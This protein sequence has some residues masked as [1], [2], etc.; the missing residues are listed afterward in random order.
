MSESESASR[1]HVFIHAYR[2]VRQAIDGA[3]AAA[4]QL[5]ADPLARFAFNAEREGAGYDPLELNWDHVHP[6][7]TELRKS[8][9]TGLVQAADAETFRVIQSA[10]CA[11]DWALPAPGHVGGD[12]RALAEVVDRF[13]EVAETLEVL[14]DRWA[15]EVFGEWGAFWFGIAARGQVIFEYLNEW[16]EASLQPAEIVTLLKRPEAKDE[17]AKRSGLKEILNHYQKAILDALDGCALKKDDLALAVFRASDQGNRLYREGRLIEMR[18]E[19][20]VAH[21]YGVGY[22]RP[23]AP[24]PNLVRPDVTV[25]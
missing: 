10:L 15:K 23:D 3:R 7:I 18:T 4:E 24:P 14:C 20:L 5:E 16:P 13:L 17:E 6:F 19:G 2:V 1:E 25:I 12:P 8:T 21:M 22:Y 11:T 9:E